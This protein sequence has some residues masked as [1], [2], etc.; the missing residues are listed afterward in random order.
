MQTISMKSAC[1]FLYDDTEL[2]MTMYVFMNKK[3]DLHSLATY[4]KGLVTELHTSSGKT[5]L[6]YY[7]NDI[8]FVW[9]QLEEEK[10]SVPIS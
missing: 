1:T 7:H 5:Y 9:D 6:M 2:P 10:V 8:R 4:H 3:E